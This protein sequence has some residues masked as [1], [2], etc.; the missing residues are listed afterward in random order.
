MDILKI[1]IRGVKAHMKYVKSLN[2]IVDKI[3]CKEPCAMICRSKKEKDELTI[4]LIVT[5]MSLASIEISLNL[6]VSFW[7]H[8]ICFLIS[9]YVWESSPDTKI[10]Q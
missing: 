3:N 6:D 4:A 1:Y 9:R 5:T 10:I 2:R 7:E 8:E